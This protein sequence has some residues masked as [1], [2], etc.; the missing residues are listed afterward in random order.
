MS[1][2]IILNS[3]EKLSKSEILSVIRSEEQYRK[4]LFQKGEVPKSLSKEI[5]IISEN[6]KFIEKREE[7]HT[8]YYGLITG[9]NVRK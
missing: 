2:Y 9:L 3:E 8:Y 1:N 4:T 5:R 7:P 6:R